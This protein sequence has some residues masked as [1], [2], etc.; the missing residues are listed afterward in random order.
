MLRTDE[1]KEKPEIIGDFSGI[2]DT[3]S[4]VHMT[5][6][7]VHWSQGGFYNPGKEFER[8]RGKLSHTSN[9]TV[10][11]QVLTIAQLNFDSYSTVVYHASTGYFTETDLSPLRS[12]TQ[13]T[14]PISLSIV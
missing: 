13:N 7:S 12:S 2:N 8:L 3:V 14:N 6:T 9:S 10:A 1:P 4:A 5:K 11:G